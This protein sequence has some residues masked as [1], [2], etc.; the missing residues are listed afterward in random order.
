LLFSLAVLCV[1]SVLECLVEIKNLN[2]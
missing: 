2:R 1:L